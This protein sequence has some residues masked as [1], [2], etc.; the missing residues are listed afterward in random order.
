[1]YTVSLSAISFGSEPAGPPCECNEIFENYLWHE[2]STLEPSQ[3]LRGPG[4]YALRVMDIGKD[5]AWVVDSF[6][7]LTRVERISG[8]ECPVLY[9]GSTGKLAQ[10]CR[11]LTKGGAQPY[12]RYYHSYS[13]AGN[14]STGYLGLEPREKAR[15][16][17][18]SYCIITARS[19]VEI[20]LSMGKLCDERYGNRSDSPCEIGGRSLGICLPLIHMAM[21]IS[22]FN[23]LLQTLWLGSAARLASLSA[24]CEPEAC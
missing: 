20:L 17:I 14:S 16:E 1:M 2:L 23:E 9:I 5:A 19:T 3:L 10:K 6:S 4:V 11:R 13:A 8:S 18:D 12:L 24:I 21:R 22:T 15:A 7:S